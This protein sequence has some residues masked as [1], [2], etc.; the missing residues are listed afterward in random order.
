MVVFVLGLG[1][2]GYVS[3]DLLH[4]NAR[5]EVLRHAG[6]LRRDIKPVNI[7]MRRDG[8]PVLLDFGSARQTRA[9]TELTTIV[10]PGYAPLEQYHE[11]GNQGPWSDLYALGDR[12]LYRM[13]F[14][15]AMD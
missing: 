1:V 13:E 15:A 11:T 12:A 4:K 5:D 3:Y 7:F 2:S 6:Y 9:N 8:G 10:T 14:L